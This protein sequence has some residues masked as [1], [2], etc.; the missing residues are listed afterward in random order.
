M[1]N[2]RLSYYSSAALS[3]ICRNSFSTSYTGKLAS[4]GKK[5]DSS[6]DRGVPFEF[7]IGTGQVIK[8][9]WE[10]LCPYFRSRLCHCKI[11]LYVTPLLSLLF[12][13][14]WDEGV[15]QMSLGEKAV[16]HISSD[17]GYGSQVRWSRVAHNVLLLRIG[18]DVEHCSLC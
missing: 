7:K 18:A 13:Q 14:G 17:Y 9:L 5:F 12:I 2:T 1:I 10:I 11:L 6:V 3:S 8:G 15:I 16:L 4:N